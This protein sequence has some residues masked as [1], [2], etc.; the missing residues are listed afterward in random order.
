[1]SDDFTRGALLLLL[2]LWV[3]LT[4]F[5][6]LVGC[7]T[8]PKVKPLIYSKG[9]GH[10]SYRVGPDGSLTMEPGSWVDPRYPDMLLTPSWIEQGELHCPC[11][12]E[13]GEDK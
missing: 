1:M 7:A 10:V 11:A 5:G 9:D 2:G 13:L 12:P 3:L 4:C 6:L 8:P